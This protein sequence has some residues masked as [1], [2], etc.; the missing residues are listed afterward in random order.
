M[1]LPDLGDQD[2][3][4]ALC[5][6]PGVDPEVWFSEDLT[7]QE[8]AVTFCSFC[9]HGPNGDDSCFLA[10]MDMDRQQGQSHGIWSGRTAR[11]RQILLE[12]EFNNGL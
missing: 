3:P 10:A 5:A 1:F 2:F 4:G 8:I 6:D 9:V 7:L 12:E 11:E